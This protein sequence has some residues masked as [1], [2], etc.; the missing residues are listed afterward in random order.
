MKGLVESLNKLRM[1]C[2]HEDSSLY[3]AHITF[4]SE[5]YKPYVSTTAQTT[6]E[7]YNFFLMFPMAAQSFT[8][9]LRNILNITGISS[10][11]QVAAL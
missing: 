5:T 2:H 6:V 8:Q 9:S 4:T 3:S 11:L 1:S 10:Y 7:Q